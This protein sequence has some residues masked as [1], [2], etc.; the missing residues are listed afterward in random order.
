VAQN[1][2][3]TEDPSIWVRFPLRP[4]QTLS[5]IDDDDSAAFSTDRPIDIVAWTTT[6]WTLLSHAG[7][8]V[9][10]ELTYR[11]VADPGDPERLLLI[12]EDLERPVPALV[13]GDGK[14]TRV[15]LREAS[16]VARFAGRSL[17][18]A[19]YDRPFPVEPS[20][21]YRSAEVSDAAGF[22]ILLADYVTLAE[23]TGAVHTAPLFGEDDEKRRAGSRSTQ[24]PAPTIPPSGPSS[25][26]S[27][28]T[29]SRTPTRRSSAPFGSG[30]ACSTANG[31]TTATPSAGAAINRC[32]TTRRRAGS[33]V[34]P[35]PA[36]G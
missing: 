7:I 23:G 4:G 26:R 25:T 11:A 20:R 32:S 13:P 31:T 14:P 3:D 24:P 9:H 19:L 8:A 21:P 5:A 18:G 15:D 33:C 16:T 34:R 28:A 2:R 36:N 22:R 30:A 27:T 35:P 17:E 10:P 12:A 6:P 1:Y 29:G